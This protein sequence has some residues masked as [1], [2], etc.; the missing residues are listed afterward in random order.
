MVAAADYVIVATYL[1]VTAAVGVYFSR[2]NVGTEGYFLGSK[3]I[4]GMLWYWAP[5]L[6]AS[7]AVMTSKIAYRAFLD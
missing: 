5:A 4:P 2:K 6:R 1:L 7:H 3:G